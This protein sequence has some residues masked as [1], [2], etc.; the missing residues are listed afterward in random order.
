MLRA[1]RLHGTACTLGCASTATTHRL[2]GASL[3]GFPFR[4]DPL[5]ERKAWKPFQYTS[6]DPRFFKRLLA[7]EPFWIPT[8]RVPGHAADC[9]PRAPSPR[10]F[11]QDGFSDKGIPF[12]V[13]AGSRSPTPASSARAWSGGPSKPP[14]YIF[15]R[16]DCRRSVGGAPACAP[17]MSDD[18]SEHAALGPGEP[19]RSLSSAM[20]IRVMGAREKTPNRGGSTAMKPAC[21][22][23]ATTGGSGGAL[24]GRC[25]NLLPPASKKN[26]REIA[27]VDVPV[28][29]KAGDE[30]IASA[31]PRHRSSARSTEA[32]GLTCATHSALAAPGRQGRDRHR[33][34]VARRRRWHR[35]AMAYV[36]AR[37]LVDLDP[38]RAQ[39]HP[40]DDHRARRGLCLR[41]RRDRPPSL[42]KRR[43]RHDGALGGSTCWSTT[44]ASAPAPGGSKRSGSALGSRDERQT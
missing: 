31:R 13:S 19:F 22:S 44:S 34:R 17:A 32:R 36:F 1:R 28:S 43:R 11:H 24:Q 5:P 3:D 40:L 15:G 27:L 38:D 16:C 12:R 4:M 23:K 29:F 14:L 37:D 33:R 10:L 2:N 30:V 41:G 21:T 42:R 6:L 8:R 39:L 7:D 26:G 20:D 35:K 25:A 18:G 9:R